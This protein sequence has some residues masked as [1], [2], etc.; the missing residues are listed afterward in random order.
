MSTR[1]LLGIDVGTTMMKSVIFDL[2]GTEVASAAHETNII[3]PHP[4]WAEQDM[5]AV[6]SATSRSISDVLQ[7]AGIKGSDVAGLSL[8]AQGAGTWLIDESGKPVRNAVSWL[9]GRAGSII[10]E[11]REDGTF[12]AMTQ[13]CGLVYYSGSG[14]GIIFPWF[15]RNDANTLERARW[16]LWPKDWVRFCLTG[17][18]MT[19]ETDPSMGMIDLPSRRYSSKVQE[20]AGIEDYADRLPPVK[21]SAD[22]AGTVTRA[23]AEETGLAEGTPVAVGAWDVTSTALGQ[24]CFK[25]NQGFSILGTAG[26]HGVIT[27]STETD[28]AYSTSVHT[29]PGMYL[30][31][32]MAMTAANN[33]D[34]FIG[35]FGESEERKAKEEGRSKFDVINDLIKATPIGSNGVYFLPFLQGERAPFVE[36]NARG[37]FLGLGDWSKRADMYRAVYEGVALATRHNYEAM[38]SGSKFDTIRLGG[39][40]ARD[41]LWT[42]IIADCTGKVMEVTSGS[43]YGARGAAINAGIALGYFS[44]YEEAVQSMVS[45]E[46][47]QEPVPANTQRYTEIYGLYTELVD[48]HMKLW[49]RMHAVARGAD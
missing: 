21:S 34:W 28:S 49:P 20:L 29:V 4:G 43:E 24:G 11:W 40:G 9:D 15:V 6:W 27:D 46:R 36:P 32:S 42:Q 48:S 10:D 1:Y 22:L 8:C 47:V 25:A 12:E 26:I 33:L 45:V 2:N 23:A 18:V 41:R 39:G 31:H 7:K 44:S 19:D 5:N 14:P 35:E 30:V 37:E 38:E 3:H 17:E 16:Q 13:A